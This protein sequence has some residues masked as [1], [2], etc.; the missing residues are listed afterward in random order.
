MRQRR[1]LLPASV[2][3]AFTLLAQALVIITLAQNWYVPWWEW[4]LL[5]LGALGIVAYAARRQWREERFSDLYLEDTR[6]QTRNIDNV[7]DADRQPSQ[8]QLR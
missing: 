4:H 3:I 5:Y 2:I 7:F 8:R 6:G 1:R